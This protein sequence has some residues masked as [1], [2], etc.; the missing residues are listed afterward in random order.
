MNYPPNFI[1]NIISR[2]LDEKCKFPA[3]RRGLGF[4]SDPLFHLMRYISGPPFAAKNSLLTFQHVK[5]IP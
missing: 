3:F 1:S 2:A 5:E 4:N